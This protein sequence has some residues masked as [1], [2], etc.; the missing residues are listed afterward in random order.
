MWEVVGEVA[1]FGV[2]QLCGLVY[3]LAV[4]RT[5]IKFMREDIKELQGRV[6]LLEFGA[7]MLRKQPEPL[8]EQF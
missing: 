8:L 4:M 5:T 7:K 3:L 2:A 1:I 6:R